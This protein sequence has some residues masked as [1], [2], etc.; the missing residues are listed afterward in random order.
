LFYT[1]AYEKW[2]AKYLPQVEVAPST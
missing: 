1:D 2:E